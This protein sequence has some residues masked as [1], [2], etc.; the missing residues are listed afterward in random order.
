MTYEIP[1]KVDI[2]RLPNTP[3]INMW[4]SVQRNGGCEGK[5][6]NL[7]F[8]GTIHTVRN[9]HDSQVTYKLSTKRSISTFS[10]SNKN[11]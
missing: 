11:S 10:Y 1:V 5:A 7:S 6:H 8:P 2:Y 3:F 4:I 9:T